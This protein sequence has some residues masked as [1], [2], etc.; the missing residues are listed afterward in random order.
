MA[1]A[2][3][4]LRVKSELAIAFTTVGR[5]VGQGT[6]PNAVYYKYIM[7][8]VNTEQMNNCPDCCTDMMMMMMIVY[9]NLM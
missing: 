6:E 4:T 8:R 2:A 7:Q 1:A 5:S 3:A 9:A